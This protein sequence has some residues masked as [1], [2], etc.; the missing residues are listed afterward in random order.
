M[1][2]NECGHSDRQYHA[3][4]MCQNCYYSAYY[5]RPENKARSRAYH[6]ARYARP[7]TKAAIKAR[8][9]AYQARPEIRAIIKARKAM[10]KYKAARKTGRARPAVRARRFSTK[11][12]ISYE[13]ALP[14]YDNPDRTCWICHRGMA[15][16]LDHDHGTR[17]IRGWTHL[18]CNTAEGSVMSS[19]DPIATAAT[20][21]QIAL[22]AQ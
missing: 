17:V 22:G 6:L 7:E 14:W 5:A 20:L 1:K 9:A 18:G 10:P 19:P 2:T 12:G 4:G 8:V 21:L 16:H 11:H 15:T 3:K 13:K